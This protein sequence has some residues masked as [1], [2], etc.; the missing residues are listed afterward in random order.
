VLGQ[1]GAEVD[2]VVA[3]AKCTAGAIEH[4]RVHLVVLLGPG[5]GGAD[6]ARHRGV[7][8]VQALGPVQRD[9]GDARL[10]RVL[11]GDQGGEHAVSSS[12]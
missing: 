6:L 12:R 10:G 8:R 4:D 7:D 1:A 11:A 9:A 3:G 5:H 2:E